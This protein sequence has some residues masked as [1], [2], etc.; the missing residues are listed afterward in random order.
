MLLMLC[1]I[2]VSGEL[3][4]IYHLALWPNTWKGCLSDSASLW[5]IDSNR[6]DRCGHASWT[7]WLYIRLHYYI[8]YIQPLE[9]IYAMVRIL[10]HYIYLIRICPASVTCLFWR[11]TFLCLQWKNVV[12]N[13]KQ[14]LL[15]QSFYYIRSKTQAAPHHFL[16]FLPVLV[17]SVPC[18]VLII[19]HAVWPL[20]PSG[21]F[22]P[23]GVPPWGRDLRPR[24]QAQRQPHLRPLALP[25]GLLAQLGLCLLSARAEENK[26]HFFHI[27]M[28]KTH[29]CQLQ[30][31]ISL[32]LSFIQ[33]MLF[34]RATLAIF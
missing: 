33:Q 11:A 22:L 10:Q 34:W 9:G 23:C 8:Y 20:R 7:Q 25:R 15:Q 6:C 26:T 14:L 24:Q 12:N 28:V 2:Y 16:Y 18:L 5:V 21:L 31:T 27:Y 32:S 17:C 30:P 3:W 19:L 13:N 1:L 4:T 29:F